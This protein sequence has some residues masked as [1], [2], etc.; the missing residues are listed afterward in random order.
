MFFFNGKPQS[1]SD[2]PKYS[3]LES[4]M[5]ENSADRLLQSTSDDGYQ[6]H[7]H[8]GKKQMRRSL[9]SLVILFLLL[10]ISVIETMNLIHSKSRPSASSKTEGRGSV[11]GGESDYIVPP[12]VLRYQRRPE[13]S[14]LQHPWTLPAGDSLDAVWDNLLS[15]SSP[16]LFKMHALMAII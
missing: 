11:E 9:P 8:G 16:I 7:S 5:E 2:F 10:Y 14:E 3:V 1:H 15:G 6:A 4:D 12:S 13:W